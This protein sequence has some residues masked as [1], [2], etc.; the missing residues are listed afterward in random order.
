MRCPY[1]NRGNCDPEYVYN[2]VEAYGTS[3]CRFSCRH[4]GETVKV[5][6]ERRVVFG[7]AAKT[8]EDSDWSS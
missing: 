4:C 5:W 3:L 6:A 7:K 1:C 8:N 2:N